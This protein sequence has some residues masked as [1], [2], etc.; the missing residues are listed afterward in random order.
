MKQKKK[1]Q[2]SEKLTEIR[3]AAYEIAKKNDEDVSVVF[4]G[5]HPSIDDNESMV[6]T[7]ST[8]G[9]LGNILDGFINAME[10]DEGLAKIMKQ[11]VMLYYAKK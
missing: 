4:I 7:A 1:E 11:A 2:I 3:D 8:I 10:E 9:R 6:A 5:V